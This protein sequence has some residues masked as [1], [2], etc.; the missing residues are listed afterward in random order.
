M[1][2]VVDDDPDV[3][4]LFST[5]LRGSEF[6]LILGADG[7]HA[8]QLARTEQPA[9]IVLDINMPAAKGFVAHDRL[10]R[11]PNLANVPIVYISAD[12]A[13]EPAAIAAGAA[14]FLAKPLEKDGVLRTLRE[15]WR[16]PS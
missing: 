15:V 2:K 10:K 16:P 7:Y 13:A 6:Q 5:W 11:M 4:T 1:I 9:V 12:R 8:V 14:R 3:R